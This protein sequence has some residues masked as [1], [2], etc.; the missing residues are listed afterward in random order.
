MKTQKI[1][2]VQDDFLLAEGLRVVIT[3]A[4]YDVVG[5]AA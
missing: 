5:E 2:L 3:D 4:G 1:L